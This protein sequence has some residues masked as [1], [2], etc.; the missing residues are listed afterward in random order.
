ML[1]A[2]KKKTADTADMIRA[3]G[4]A[5]LQNI[6][7]KAA[8]AKDS[9]EKTWARIKET[10]A[11]DELNMNRV[12]HSF[13]KDLTLGRCYGFPGTDGSLWSNI[14]AK[15][16]IQSAISGIFGQ[17]ELAPLSW[18]GHLL[19][20]F[21][22]ASFVF[23]MTSLFSSKAVFDE[24][25]M[26]GDYWLI[27]LCVWFTTTFYMNFAYLFMACPCLY[28]DPYSE[29]TAHNTTRTSIEK[30]FS[31]FASFASLW[32]FLASCAYILLGIVL[33]KDGVTFAEEYAVNQVLSL[34]VW[35]YVIII[36]WGWWTFERE[37]KAFEE[38]WW[39]YFI[40]DA[41]IRS[42]ECGEFI[43]CPPPTSYTELARFARDR[44][45]GPVDPDYAKWNDW[46]GLTPSARRNSA[47]ARKEGTGT[48]AKE[49][50]VNPMTEGL[51]G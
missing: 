24:D 37:K 42:E 34:F 15:I 23:F 19:Y 7:A 28:I 43:D 25:D 50:K 45:A 30:C 16:R 49:E 9:A 8:K 6:A 21:A 10:H 20:I 31:C 11:I 40:R 44:H 12:Y 1:D 41:R 36:L 35:D 18:L 48:E 47:L 32:I 27:V 13:R 17:H 29:V 26:K 3:K 46:F 22:C 4:E 2:I 39:D 5:G 14:K 51:V 33:R 38:K